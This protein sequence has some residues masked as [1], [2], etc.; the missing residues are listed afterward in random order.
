MS[1]KASV[2]KT[3]LI[4][5]DDAAIR[6][7]LKKLLTFLGFDVSAV[8]SG[9]EAISKLTEEPD[10]V[11]LDLR[12]TE[13]DGVEVLRHIRKNNLPIKVAVTTGLSDPKLMREVSELRPDAVFHKP[14]NPGSLIYWLENA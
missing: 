3:T 10:S 13:G 7:S 1:E 12:L 5:E 8:E 11:L 14:L 2:K 6:A 9:A 4:V